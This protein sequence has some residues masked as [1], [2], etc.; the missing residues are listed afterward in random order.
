MLKKL[1]IPLE[2]LSLVLKNLTSGSSKRLKINA[3]T[4][5]AT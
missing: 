3:V 4:K 1:P 5:G 2:V